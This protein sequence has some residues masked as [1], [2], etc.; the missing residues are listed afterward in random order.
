MTARPTRPTPGPAI[1]RRPGPAG[2]ARPAGEAARDPRAAFGYPSGARTTPVPDVLFSRDL[3]ALAD[4]LALRVLLWAIWQ[5]H[6]RPAGAPPAVRA[7]D[8][9]SDLGL[10]R[11]AAARLDAPAGE[12]SSRT[13][14]ASTAAIGEACRVL[15]AQ[16]LLLDGGGWYAVNDRA[17]RQVIDDVAADPGR[18]PDLAALATSSNATSSSLAAGQAARIAIPTESDEQADPAD[19]PNIFV[20]YE[21]TIGMVSPILADELAEAAATYPAAWLTH[22]FRLAAAAGAREWSYVRAILT[23]WAREGYD[24]DD[25]EIAG[26]RAETSRR[27][28]SEGPYAAWVKH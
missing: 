6:R 14:A 22:A 25:D 15:V 10:R 5:V 7:S 2:S 23:R 18:W 12:S 28:D 20:L 13:G 16:G 21:Q 26:R 3:A 24:G 17:G 11:A 9:A 8:V 1:S 4:P 19:R 27:P